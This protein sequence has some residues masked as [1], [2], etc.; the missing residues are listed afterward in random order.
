MTAPAP[1]RTT[2]GTEEMETQMSDFALVVERVKA[3]AGSLACEAPRMLAFVSGLTDPEVLRECKAQAAAIE[4]YLAQRRDA[5]VEEYNAAVKVKARVAH[6]LGEVLAVTV[7]HRGSRGVGDTVSP[8]LPKEITRKQSSRAQ[9]LAR[10]PWEEIEAGI[11]EATEKNE[12]AKLSRIT[13]PLLQEQKREELAARSIELVELRGQ[14]PIILA[15]P[16]WRYEHCKTTNREIEN[17]YPT[18]PLEEICAL[19]AKGKVPAA[20]DAVL[21]LW[22]PSPKRREAESVMEAWGFEYRTDMVWVKDRPGMG[23]WVRQ[24]HEAL[25][26]GRRGNFPCPA[27]ANRL[28]SV[29]FAPRG[30]HSEKP[31][32]FYEAIERM[33]PGLPRFELFQRTPRPGW[34][35]YG[36]ETGATGGDALAT[37]A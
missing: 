13:T 20:D 11:D 3:G 25:L 26:I 15:D 32:A 12:R 5:S 17:H 30:R 8:T 27:E 2:T 34:D 35:G 9:Q 24:R 4:E 16:P 7:N 33:Y 6:R 10:V 37:S 19:A 36:N 18:M 29:I 23:Y 21:F 22:S 14:Y 1:Q 28:E 31:E